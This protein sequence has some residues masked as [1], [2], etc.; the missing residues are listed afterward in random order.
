M[1]PGPGTNALYI[2]RIRHVP[3]GICNLECRGC[4]S[5]STSR[6]GSLSSPWRARPQEPLHVYGAL[7]CSNGCC[8][9]VVE[10]AA[11][12]T[13]ECRC[14]CFAGEVVKMPMQVWSIAS[15]S[16]SR[17]FL[18]REE[19]LLPTPLKRA[20]CKHVPPHVE[21]FV[22]LR[23]SSEMSRARSNRNVFNMRSTAKY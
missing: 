14:H 15:D 20:Q 9:T 13:V 10:Y 18:R 12:A 8:N 21:L 17:N 6:N 22:I 1:G 16:L 4:A 23:Y 5:A 11:F 7:S 3:R 19:S 2:D